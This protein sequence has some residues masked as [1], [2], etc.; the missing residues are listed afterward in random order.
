VVTVSAAPG[1]SAVLGCQGEP[2]GSDPAGDPT[3]V[4]AGVEVCRP[5]ALCIGC[6][7]CFDECRCGGGD[8]A[9]CAEHCGGATEAPAGADGGLV[10]AP[11]APKVAT[12]VMDPFEMAP[13]EEVFKCQNFS[14]PFKEHVVVLSTESF[15]T[16]GSHHL[17]VFQQADGGPSEIVDCSGLEFSAHLHLAQK[18][19]QQT[20]YP[21]GVGRLLMSTEGIRIQMHYFN[22][23][24]R[25][26]Q[27]EVAVTIQADAPEAVPMLASH[28]FI[29][30]FGISVPPR[31]A[32]E[33]TKSCSMPKDIELFQAVS[34]MHRRGVSFTARGD[35]D[36][37]LYE[38][39]EWA[40]PIP[41]TFD[42]PRSLGAGSR[43]DI[44]C[45]YLNESD[46]TLT[47]GSSADTNEM[48]IFSGLYY[49]AGFAEGITC[50]F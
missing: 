13:G 35:G 38:T 45:E 43:I 42:P 7:T 4:D 25:W 40:E 2:P 12:L 36:Q 6:A 23:S 1:S 39:T 31:S 47:F 48:C 30:T 9:S 33:V 50:L 41:W 29:N 3:G 8:V 21:P 16:A 49:P 19:Q 22:S 14:N 10:Y 27:P 32:G 44:R 15:M 17:F 26:I 28:V 5:D 18:S 37:L 46:H 11:L 34:H 24:S 20:T